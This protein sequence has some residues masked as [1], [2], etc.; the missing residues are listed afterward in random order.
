MNAA[1]KDTFAEAGAL[2]LKWF[3]EITLADLIAD[4]G[5]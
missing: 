2:L 5:R 3:S 4:F 1:L